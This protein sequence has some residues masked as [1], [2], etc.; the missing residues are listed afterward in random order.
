MIALSKSRRQR[1]LILTGGFTALFLA[2]VAAGLA[3]RPH[4]AIYVPGEKVAGITSSL[5]RGLPADYPG[6]TFSDVTR[7]AGITFQHFYG[8]RS[9]QLPE[10]MGSGAAWGDYN[11]DGYPDLFLVNEAGPLTMTTEQVKASPAR[12]ALYHNNGDGTFTDVTDKAGLGG[13]KGCFMGAAWG[14]YDNDGYED[15]FITAYG[16]NRLFHNDGN[17]HFTEVTKK[18]GVGGL[19][20]FWTGASW[21]DYD[22]DG[23]LDLYICGYVKYHSPRPEEAGATSKQND[24]DVPF[25][26]NPSSYPPERNLLYHN[27]G[28]G[29]FTEVARQAGVDDPSGRSLSAT[30][31]DFDGNGWP[32]LYVN[33]DVSMHAFYRNLG[34]GH[35]QDISVSSWACDYRGGMGIAVGDWDNNGQMD[36]FLTH[37]LAQEKALYH[38]MWAQNAGMKSK[39]RLR[40]I[41]ISDQVG[42]GQSTLDYVGWGTSFVDFDNDG[43]LDLVI[44]NG[45]T[46]EDPGDHTRLVPMKNQLFWNGSRQDGYFE[47]NGS[48]RGFFEVEDMTGDA[49]RQPNVARGLAVADYDRDGAPDM[50]ITR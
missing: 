37:W 6:T 13:L 12:C 24:T 39:D 4:P 22:R 18:A 41:D 49:L 25:T 50:V 27:N 42:L 5:G 26:I 40:F 19:K 31:C 9:S 2:V 38:N 17:G 33:N 36:L 43:R 15:L 8:K 10:D 32:D 7:Q 48:D 29:T 30:W 11:N 46:L 28:D 20:G 47:H 34:N 21:G 45:S 44:A 3:L 23:R 16:E 14:D 1:R 35:F